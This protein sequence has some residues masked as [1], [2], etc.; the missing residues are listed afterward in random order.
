MF[1]VNNETIIPIISEFYGVLDGNSHKITITSSFVAT[2]D[3]TYV[4]ILTGTDNIYFTQ[5]SSLFQTVSSS[6]SIKNLYIDY[7][8]DYKGLNSSNVMFAPISAIN[9]GEIDNIRISSVTIKNLNGNG[10]NIAFAG[11]LVGVNYGTISNCVNSSSF[12]YSMAQQL[13]VKFG[14]GG[15][16]IFNA[17][18][19]NISGT[20]TNCYNQ[21]DKQVTVY[22]M[23]T[24]VYLAGITL[25]NSGTISV[26][27]NDGS[28]KLSQQ[29][30]TTFTGYYAG[31]TVTNSGILEYLYN[32]GKIEN[33]KAMGILNYGGIAYAVTGG[34]INSL[35]TTVEDQPIIQSCTTT[36]LAKV[37]TDF[38][39]ST[40]PVSDIQ[41]KSLASISITCPNGKI[42][43]VV[44]SGNG[45]KASIQ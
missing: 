30:V 4:G 24:T 7:I 8:I 12:T 9:Y 43:K 33:V 26:S 23:N 37:G 36:S 35:V 3:E 20:I 31:I 11:G 6:A 13:A 34:S 14:Y 32:N 15:M 29:S 5:Y 28:L 42:L 19:S 21:G 25:A 45:Y 2:L 41:V 18:K 38:Y 1:I 17:K 44:S 10:E 22:V 39:A 16:A 40:N 27:G